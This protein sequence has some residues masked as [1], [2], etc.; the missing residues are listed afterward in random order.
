[1][2][3]ASTLI[4]RWYHDST[5]TS[6]SSSTASAVVAVV[7]G[8][9]SSVSDRRSARRRL[10][11]G[12]ASSS[13]A[14]ASAR[15]VA[16]GSRSLATC[17]VCQ[18]KVSAMRALRSRPGGRRSVASRHGCDGCGRPTASAAAAWPAAGPR[19][20]GD[21]RAHP[22]RRRCT[23]SPS[24]ATRAPRTG[25]SPTACG[26]TGAAIYHYFDSKAELYAAVYEAVFA[27]VFDELERAV[28]CQP[29]LVAQYAALLNATDRLNRDD[30]TGPA[31]VVGVAGDAQRHPELTNLHPAPAAAQQRVLPP[32]RRR[33]RRARRAEPRRRRA[34]RRGP[35]ERRRVRAVAAVGDHRRRPPP[36]GRRRRPAALL[37]RHPPR[38]ADRAARADGGGSAAGRRRR[39]SSPAAAGGGRGRGRAADRSAGA[40]GWRS[41][42]CSVL[43]SDDLDRQ[44]ARCWPSEPIAVH[45]NSVPAFVD[46]GS[47]HCGRRERQPVELRVAGHVALD[48][49]HRLVGEVLGRRAG[50][51][52]RPAGGG[53]G[54]HRDDERGGA[55]CG[56]CVATLVAGRRD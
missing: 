3:S 13:K 11:N 50:H 5:M 9:A 8:T 41:V 2:T 40:G 22:A 15:S 12:T 14:A 49:R 32:A 55:A 18:R 24:A 26:L 56:M 28:A 17:A 39:P 36:R 10:S 38:G 54:E 20:G 44:R 51:R 1:M 43:R 33:R 19:L 52:T 34:R 21:A 4:G 7:A 45:A 35:P 48:E 46:A 23:C 47:S 27:R 31:F 42:T 6:S 29:T 16:R 30:P 25:P 53:G 37:R